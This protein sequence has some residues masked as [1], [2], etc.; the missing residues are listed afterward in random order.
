MAS[1]ERPSVVY[2]LII[3]TGLL[4]AVAGA[5]IAVLGLSLPDLFEARVGRSEVRTS[6]VGLA[7]MVVGS[8]LA[9]AAGVGKP[10]DVRIFSP[11]PEPALWRRDIEWLLRPLAA[12]AAGSLAALI[13]SLAL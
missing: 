8:G 3:L 10:R 12:L 4:L 11:Q 7:I 13:L 5:V 9:L 6:S 1:S 2:S